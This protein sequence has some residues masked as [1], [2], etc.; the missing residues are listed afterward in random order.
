M[1]KTIS[2]LLVLIMT[3]CL[4]PTTAFAADLGD[5]N[6]DGQT[7][8]KDSYCLKMY[9]S[10]ATELEPDA[11]AAADFNRDLSINGADSYFLKMHL[12]GIKDTGYK[13]VVNDKDIT[14]SSYASYGMTR[15]LVE[16]PLVAV[17]EGLGAD[18][19]YVSDSIVE[20]G[21]DQIPFTSY[22][23]EKYILDLNEKTLVV[24]GYNVNFLNPVPGGRMS[25]RVHDGDVV[26]DRLTISV[27]LEGMG[28]DLIFEYDFNNKVIY[29]A[30]K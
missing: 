4:Y 5:V 22:Y 28:H 27:L 15:E 10:G 19:I 12:A 6:G 13:L 29:I 25:C 18:I 16:I 7:D 21:F 9:L 2:V 1:K 23:R 11:F 30:E 26:L 8:A 17:C 3:F 14:K 20:I 24:E